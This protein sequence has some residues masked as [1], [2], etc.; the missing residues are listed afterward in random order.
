MT[1]PIT[2]ILPFTGRVG[3]YEIGSNKVKKQRTAQP[4]QQPAI[5]SGKA[6]INRTAD[7]W[8]LGGLSIATWS[9]MALT[10]H[11]RPYSA[12]LSSRFTDFGNSIG[13]LGLFVQYPHF[14]AFN[15]I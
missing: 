1:V 13:T 7:F 11:L 3:V 15:I 5:E 10:L 9:M 14:M 6:L 12:V 8:I 4:P 2:M